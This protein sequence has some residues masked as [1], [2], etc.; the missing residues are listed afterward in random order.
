MS[1]P[2]QPESA[3]GLESLLKR[4]QPRLKQILVKYRIPITDAEDV[5]Q[6]A[7]LALVYQWSS[8]RNPEAWLLGTVRNKC[9]LYWREQHRCPYDAVD[10]SVLEWIAEPKG[11]RQEGLN[12]S[13]DMQRVLKR[14]PRRCRALLLLRYGLGYSPPEL[15][16]ELGYRPSS[17]GKIT[18]RCL[19]ALSQQMARVGFSAPRE[20]APDPPP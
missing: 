5:L 4:V 18:A 3:D 10:P 14:L 6:Q 15:A 13:H 16:H 7:L 12:L 20:P 1:V 19:G 2:G 8:V 11:P 9:R 17:I